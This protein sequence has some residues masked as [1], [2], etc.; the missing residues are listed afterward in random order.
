MKITKDVGE[1]VSPTGPR[2]LTNEIRSVLAVTGAGTA[3][4][5][6]TRILITRGWDLFGEHLEGWEKWAALAGAGYVAVYATIQQPDVARF[7][8]PASVVGW[9]LAAWWVSPPAPR[10][11]ATT[12]AVVVEEPGET[13]TLDTLTEVARRVAEDRRGAH[14]ADLLQQP[15]FA[16]W[17]QADLKA[18]ITDLEVPVK[19]FKLILDGRQRVR[20]GVR[21][22]DLP[23]PAAPAP[24]SAAPSGG[25]VEPAPP[26][27]PD[28][29]P[30]PQ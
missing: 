19:G 1:H 23:A 29:A 16:G 3:L 6:G 11:T 26:T 12:D 7:V 5:R 27:A 10:G 24:G 9:C 13:L 18:A 30:G 15:E 25:P 4:W 14:L 21:L 20:D 8:V 2:R 17:E 22:R 28:P